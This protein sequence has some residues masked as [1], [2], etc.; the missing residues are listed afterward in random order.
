MVHEVSKF[1]RVQTRLLP[2]RNQQSHIVWYTKCLNFLKSKQ[3]SSLE[4]INRAK[5]FSSN[6]VRQG[7]S[8]TNIVSS[9]R[10]ELDENT[11]PRN[12]VNSKSL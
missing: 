7:I 9:N 3:G 10:R 12:N 5:N 1:P 11:S 2:R 8:F 6:N 4:E